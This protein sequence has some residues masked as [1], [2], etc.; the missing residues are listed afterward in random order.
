[1]LEFLRDAA[2]RPDCSAVVGGVFGAGVAR[3]GGCRGD[4]SA[5][6]DC[7]GI[8]SRGSSWRGQGWNALA[9]SNLELVV[10]PA[11]FP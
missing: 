4:R 2:A 8:A 10:M 11:G 5:E 7:S 3:P 9:H 6:Q 1:M